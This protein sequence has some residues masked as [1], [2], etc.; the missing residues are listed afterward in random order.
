MRPYFSVIIPVYNR[1][2]ALDVAIRSVLAQSLQDFEIIVVDDGSQDDPQSVVRTIADP[3]IRFIRQDN[4]GGGAARNAGIDAARGRY[5]A[6]LDSDDL[7]LPHHLAAMQALLDGT[8][9]TIG[10]ARVR[11]DRGKGRVFLKPPRALAEGEHMATYLLCERGFVPTDTI[12]VERETAK[13]VRYDG[14]L[15]T[16]E[17]ADFAIRLFLDGGKFKMAEEPGA[18]WKDVWDP[19]RTSAGRRCKRFG[20]WLEA[21]KP[22][23]PRKAYHGGRGWAYAKLV[24]ANTNRLAALTLYLNALLRGCYRPSLAGV[25]ALQIFISN[26]G[27][28]ALADTAIARLGAGLR[29]TRVRSVRQAAHDA[30]AIK[31]QSV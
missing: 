20:D 16:A 19:G 31:R 10:Y 5:I 30:A 12:V 9:N 25:I 4:Q 8:V 7:L 28:R 26:A 11:V 2:S 24:A 23:I 14:N 22:V 29:E 6:P 18:V 1:A 15:R 27:Y 17:D 21:L 13:R 3:R